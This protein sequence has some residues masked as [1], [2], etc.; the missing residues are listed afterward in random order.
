MTQMKLEESTEEPKTISHLMSKEQLF[1]QTLHLELVT[2]L[3]MPQD[4][5]Q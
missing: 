3:I 2:M 5:H 1:G 4:Q